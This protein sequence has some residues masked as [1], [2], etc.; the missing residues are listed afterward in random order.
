MACCSSLEDVAAPLRR[1][2]THELALE[3]PDQDARLRLMQVAVDLIKLKGARQKM[4]FTG[5]CNGMYVWLMQGSFYTGSAASVQ[6][7][8]TLKHVAAQTAGM[9]PVDLT[10]IVADAAAAAAV[11][12]VEMPCLVAVSKGEAPSDQEQLQNGHAHT[13]SS[14]GSARGSDGQL[15]AELAPDKDDFEKALSNL[16]QRTAVAIGAPQVSFDL[17]NLHHEEII[18]STSVRQNCSYCH[19]L[20]H[21]RAVSAAYIWKLLYCIPQGESS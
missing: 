12:R 15:S 10:A 21:E 14:S 9:L 13:L 1:C 20:R 18:S 17:P 4:G 7:D 11:K 19:C 16:R 2:F 5:W 6:V 3:A 8:S